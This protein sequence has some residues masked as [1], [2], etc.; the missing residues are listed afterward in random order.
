MNKKVLKAMYSDICSKD[1]FRLQMTGVHFEEEECVASDTHILAV[2]RQG[3]KRYAT[4][5][6]SIDGVEINGNYPD[7]KRVLP[8]EMARGPLPIDLNQLLKA[9]QWHRR[10][11]ANHTDDTIV[12]DNSAFRVANVAKVLNLINIAGE[13]GEAKFYL[14]DDGSRP[15]KI[16]SPSITAIIMPVSF[17]PASVDAPREAE[18]MAFVSYE[19]VVNNYAFN[20]WRKPEPKE[21]MSWL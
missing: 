2:Y 21:E 7:Y 5:T 6:I 3:S 14:G 20:S 19:T 17:I 10:Q 4:K 16:E 9:T 12:I 8:K 13:L 11:P 18:C 15:C 1:L